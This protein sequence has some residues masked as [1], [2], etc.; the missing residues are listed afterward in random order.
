MSIALQE[1]PL[2]GQTATGGFNYNHYG[3]HSDLGNWG[4]Q[5]IYANGSVASTEGAGGKGQRTDDLRYYMSFPNEKNGILFM[6]E[7][8][9]RKGF[10]TL[11]LDGDAYVSYYI[12][13]WLGPSSEVAQEEKTTGKA[14][15]IKVFQKSLDY[16][17]NNA[18]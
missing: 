4:K 12:D 9:T 15:Y 18:V 2:D 10:N 13:K 1:Q 14:K 6:A 16:I 3:V 17:N 8:L 11:A 7:A 5:D